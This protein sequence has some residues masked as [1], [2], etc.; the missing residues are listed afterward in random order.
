M[1]YV[2]GYLI[3]FFSFNAYAITVKDKMY[4]VMDQLANT[5]NHGDLKT[6][7]N[8]YKKSDD[9]CYLST[10]IIKGYGNISKRYFEKYSNQQKMGKLDFTIDDIKKLS[11]QYSFVI[12]KYHLVRK[13]LPDANG[14]F[15]LLF[16]KIGSDWKIIVDH[17]S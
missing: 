15:T 10:N 2:L 4:A 9:T 5:W 16:E 1:K 14:V 11:N 6:F 8:I 12:G 13:N 17:T 3:L 7:L